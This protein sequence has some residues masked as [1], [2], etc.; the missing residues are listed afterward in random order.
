MAA[1]LESIVQA[2]K[3]PED[4]TVVTLKTIGGDIKILKTILVETSYPFHEAL[5]ESKSNEL[6]M[7][8]SLTTVQTVV[9]WMHS[10]SELPFNKITM[11]E[12]FNILR[13]ANQYG[14]NTLIDEII[15]HFGSRELEYNEI[16]QVFAYYKHDG[17]GKDLYTDAINEFI[18]MR[19]AVYI[20]EHGGCNGCHS[21]ACVDHRN[22][23]GYY[24]SIIKNASHQIH[25]DITEYECRVK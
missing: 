25:A 13:F 10:A 21:D 12:I 7:K 19:R 16:S 14:I 4:I 1:K 3:N 17:I 22:M 5:L 20:S 23:L 9:D 18:S 11:Q 15:N 6:E 8:Y 2:L 24:K